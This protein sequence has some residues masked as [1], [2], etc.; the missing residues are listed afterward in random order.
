MTA[1]GC[2]NESRKPRNWDLWKP[3]NKKRWEKRAEERR[4]AP[5]KEETES[6]NRPQDWDM[7]KSN[8]DQ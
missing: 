2:N 7:W 4:A 1:I 3:V 6:D 5:R 8:R